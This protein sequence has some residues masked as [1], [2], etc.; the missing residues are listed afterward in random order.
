MKILVT[1]GGGYLGSVLVPML[2]E[3]GHHVTVLDWFQHGANS[4]APLA[5]HPRFDVHRVDCRNAD[6]VKPYLKD[7]DVFIPLAALVGAPICN[8]NPIDAELLNVHSLIDV[9][10]SLS[11]DQLLINPST[12]SVYGKNATLC[13]EKTEPNP[14]VSYGVQKLKVER[15]LTGRANSISFR[16][17][18]L[19]GMSPKMRLDLLINDFTWRALKDRALVVF[20]AKAMRTC[21]H[22]ADAARA[23]VHC[24]NMRTT[25]HTVFNVGSIFVSKLQL[26]EAIK[27]QVPEFFFVE[28]QYAT[29]PDARD[30]T[31]SDAKLRATGYEP[32]ATLDDG[33]AELLKGYRMI[34]N[35][36]YGNVP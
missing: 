22:V 13:T 36:R 26:C 25:D 24:L 11:S 16:M 30:Y 3:D 1:G 8:M 33:I 31:V 20:E 4:L 27:R 7:A 5:T 21:L 2:L 17:A 32:L 10:D 9:I 6:A 28:A 23:F 12:E 18:T 35:T 19:F 15:A 34:S 14:L 29:D